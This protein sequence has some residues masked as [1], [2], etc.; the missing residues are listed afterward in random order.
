MSTDY[1]TTQ[2]SI[3]KKIKSALS[4]ASIFD[5]QTHV[6]IYFLRFLLTSGQ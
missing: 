4:I 2:L 1:N 6:F 3:N 5:I